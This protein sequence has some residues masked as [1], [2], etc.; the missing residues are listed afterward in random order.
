LCT[1]DCDGIA[2]GSDCVTYVGCVLGSSSASWTF[3]TLA[4]PATTCTRPST[5][6]THASATLT[7]VDCDSDGILDHRCVSGGNQGFLSSA[8]SCSDTWPT[9]A[10]VSQTPT[11]FPASSCASSSADGS[12]EFVCVDPPR[13]VNACAARAQ[14]AGGSCNEKCGKYSQA[15]VDTKFCIIHMK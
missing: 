1:R 9:G 15:D 2:V 10:C 5:W 11:P 7:M 3:Y 12:S 8:S 6:C 14:V 4:P 13:R